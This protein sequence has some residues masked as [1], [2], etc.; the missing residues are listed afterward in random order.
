MHLCRFTSL[1]IALLA[2]WSPA[3]AET[4]K[5]TPHI[6]DGDTLAIADRTIRLE[7][8]DAAESGQCHTDLS[9]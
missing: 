7:G 1:L 9:G 5:G 3:G 8:I 2:L 6:I 4:L